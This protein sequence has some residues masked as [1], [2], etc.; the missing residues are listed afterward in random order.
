MENQKFSFDHVFQIYNN[1]IA[2]KRLFKQTRFFCELCGFL[3]NNSKNIFN[4]ANLVLDRKV[5]SHFLV[6]EDVQVQWIFIRNKLIFNK[7]MAGIDFKI[8]T[9]N[10]TSGIGHRDK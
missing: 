9:E 5:L 4:I 1:R 6:Q 3:M 8:S 10:A 2:T 7:I